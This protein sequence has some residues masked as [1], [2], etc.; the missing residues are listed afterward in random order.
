MDNTDLHGCVISYK[1]VKQVMPERRAYID[2]K[3]YYQIDENIKNNKEL[4]FLPTYLKECNTQDIKYEKAKYKIILSGIFVDGRKVN[5]I[6]DGIEPYFEVRIPDSVDGKIETFKNRKSVSITSGEYIN[7]LRRLLNQD[8]VTRPYKTSS[9]KGKPFKY[10]QEHKSQFIRFYYHKLKNRKEAIK[11]V[12]EN[13]YET[14]TDDLSSYYRVVCRNKKLTF[15]TWS[16][17]NNYY[18]EDVTYLKGETYRINID[19]YKPY[20]GELSLKKTPE[21]LK[22][23]T[24]SMT[25]DIE[26][27]SP[28]GDVP[29]PEKD[30]NCIFCIGMTFQ[31]V[32][33]EN[34]FLRIALVDYPCDTK[35]DHLTIVC[36]SEVNIIRAF[37]DIFEK[38]QPDFIMGFNDS[39]YDWDWLIKRACATKGLVSLVARK[40]DNSIPWYEYTDDSVMKY[41]YQKKKIK[42]D[43]STF[44]EG[45]SLMMDGYIPIDVRTM[46][47]KLYPTSEKSSLKWFLEKNQLGSKED[48]PYQTMFKIYAQLREIRNNEHT[49][50]SGKGYELEFIFDKDT[51]VEMIENYNSLK[52]RLADVNKYC[53]VDAL[54]CH[55]LV[56]MRTVIQD[57]R[58]ISK[59]SYTSVYD[60]FYL[61]N[62][63]KVRNLTIAT[64]QDKNL[65]FGI[66]FSN[67]SPDERELGQYPGGYV[68]AP[69]KGLQTSKLSI[70]ERINKADLT[71]HSKRKD[72]Q[73]WLNTSD[74]EIKNFYKIIEEYGPN[75]TE[76]KKIYEIEEKYG[77]LPI[78]FKDFLQDITGR[79]VTGLDFASLYP[80]LIRAYNFSPEYCV[81]DRMY[82]K[83]LYN[84]D[85]KLTKV[86]F[87]FNGRPRKAWFVWHNNKTNPYMN[88]SENS[89]QKLDPEFKFGVYPYILD[90]LFHD[91]KTI[92]K[93]MKVYIH[94]IEQMEND[95]TKT[96][97]YI[98]AN[99]V[100]YNDICFH[101]NYYNSKQSALKVFMNT[102]YGECG[103]QNSPF[104]VLEV[105]GGITTWGARNIKF[106]KK[107]VEDKGCNVLYGDTDSIYLST[108]NKYFIDVDQL[109][110]TGK[111][112]K[113][114]YWTKLVEITFKE[115]KAL[116]NDIN[117][118]FYEDNGTIFLTMAYEEVLFPVIFTAKKKYF[119]IP[120]E[121]IANFTPKNLF[122]KGLD[123]VKR[124]VSDLLKKIFNEI[125]WT[126]VGVNNI[127]SLM[128]LVHDMVDK[129]FSSKWCIDDFIQTDVFRP[130]KKNIKVHKFVDRMK[131]IGIK[132]PTNDRF[133]YI[134]VK[135]YPY[136]YSY[137]GCKIVLKVGDKMEYVDTVKAENLEIDLDHYMRG[138]INKQLAR[139]IVYHEMFHIDPINDT[140][141]EVKIAED[142]MISNASKFINEYCK[143]YY[144]EYNTFGKT[145]KKIFTTANK[146]IGGN[147]K[148]RDGLAYTIISANVPET[149]F[150]EWFIDGIDKRATSLSAKYG[151]KHINSELKKV[152]KEDRVNKIKL[153]QKVYYG[154]RNKSII[155]VRLKSF[156][157]TMSI[158]RR[159]IRDNTTEF[160]TLYSVYQRSVISVTDILKK[161]LKIDQTL[162]NNTKDCKEYDIFD[163]VPE[164]DN[165][166]QNIMKNKADEYVE[167]IMDD[168][169][170][171]VILNNFKNLYND[172]LSAHLSYRRTENIVDTLKI[173][174]DRINRTITRPNADI[175][176][177]VIA[178]NIRSTITGLGDINL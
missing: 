129:I 43:A 107:F 117:I 85:Q 102:F 108:P 174:R 146:L 1:D 27:W 16:V 42:I 170:L 142:K 95:D 128:E 167:N 145:Y 37:A 152:G 161:Y 132:V 76:Q 12:R 166:I 147:I 133:S 120:H 111:M 13:N 8:D 68:V 99:I 79:P 18:D 38:M 106:A 50:F 82:A 56:K 176:K 17:L 80:S 162:F 39:G 23:K 160:Y 72:M 32:N 109:Y 28:D 44:V 20:T 173:R 34:P 163:F 83:K 81:T 66:L 35:P 101:R 105:A 86:D 140:D 169:K 138:S 63:M 36:G 31:W 4:L 24:L 97:G 51:P 131:E 15:G 55:E 153:M 149:G 134:I 19:D 26:T 127:Y 70:E 177:D 93:Q 148:K 112:S 5:V 92:K 122:V 157:E 62:G 29:L 165:D 91:R 115:I 49:T 71:K 84:N 96:P 21:L 159:R 155:D 25:W 33:Q 54:R 89:R 52:S 64:G 65:P 11:L 154:T 124:G 94:E 135:K 175:M 171:K 136:R 61:A 168:S 60:A 78:K 137:R 67:I 156:R 69:K 9:T 139:L 116:N 164:I 57:H 119:G 22:D 88:D 158:L 118:R 178:E 141:A 46:F 58:E 144:S 47:R 74:E 87:V 30:D 98:Q 73:Y 48:M 53:V 121:N 41:H 123:V 114:E 77:N 103:N 130:T 75:I 40:L 125:M 172:L 151:T 6:L 7:S 2:S 3:E 104:F 10:Y 110:Y 14:T 90:K 126:C 100:H 143:Q 113:I 45:C 59:L 150:V